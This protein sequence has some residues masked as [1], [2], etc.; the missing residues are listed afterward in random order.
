M[1]GIIVRRH[2]VANTPLRFTLSIGSLY[3]APLIKR[4]PLFNP[5]SD[6]LFLEQC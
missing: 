4:P 6:I 2:V 3:S 1:I 5:M